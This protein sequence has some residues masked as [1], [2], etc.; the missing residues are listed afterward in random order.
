MKKLVA[1][2]MCLIMVV[3]LFSCASIDDQGGESSNNEEN[4][5]TNGAEN[6]TPNE[7]A[8]Q[9][10]RAA[11]NDEINV[12]DKDLGE[13][14][15]KEC[16][17]PSNNLKLGE[18]VMYGEVILDMDQDG[19]SEYIIRSYAHDSI[20][21]HYHDGKVYTFAFKFKEFNNL[22]EDG[23]FNWTGDFIKYENSI[24]GVL[25]SGA[26]KLTFDGT[27]IKFEDIY[28]TIYDKNLNAKY[29][30]GDR[31]VTCDA[32]TEYTKGLPND[33]VEYTTF[34]A[35]WYNV[36]SEEEALQ[37]ASEYWNI[38]SGDIDEGT[39]YRF[40]LILKYSDNSNYCIALSWLVEGLNY[41]TIEIIEINAFTGEI[42]APTYAPG[43]KG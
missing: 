30:I 10:Y 35:P 41:S 31:E 32:M 24:T 34:E 19:V 38:K 12:F 13:I 8:L 5:T 6:L 17:F 2:L 25:N 3:C 23:S 1:I 33:F 11:I 14:K 27:E 9:M 28:K 21:L 36:I 43:A 22:K 4:S 39:G 40:S 18:S 20:V 15:L 16:R 29:Y 37:I 26:K 7:V 42:I